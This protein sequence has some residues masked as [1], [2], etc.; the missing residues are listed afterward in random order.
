MNSLIN[1][2]DAVAWPG[3][4]LLLAYWFKDDIKQFL[5]EIQEFKTA[6][7]TARKFDRL[8]EAAAQT[9]SKKIKYSII[10]QDTD[11]LNEPQAEYPREAPW[12]NMTELFISQPDQAAK[13]AWKEVK[14]RIDRLSEKINHK[15]ML[16]C[17]DQAMWLFIDNYIDTGTMNLVMGLENIILDIDA[18]ISLNS[19]QA[20]E[21]MAYSFKVCNDLDKAETMLSPAPQP[22]QTPTPPTQPQ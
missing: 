16:G 2:I 22:V 10:K 3:T 19:S 7:F 4:I 1:L 15:K 21:F 5:K 18:G 17:T 20:A 9:S 6:G 13:E 8:K 14:R 11:A 12:A